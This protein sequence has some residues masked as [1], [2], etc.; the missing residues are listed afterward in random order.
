MRLKSHFPK[1]D[2]IGP[3]AENEIRDTRANLIR[4]GQSQRDTQE[5]RGWNSS[6]LSP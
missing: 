4:R 5:S 2:V 3:I 6:T 1:Y